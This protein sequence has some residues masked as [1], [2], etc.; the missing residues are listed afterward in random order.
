MLNAGQVQ[1]RR[2]LIVGRTIS[3]ASANSIGRGASSGLSS[4][5]SLPVLP[6]SG[7]RP[8]SVCWTAREVILSPQHTGT[9]VSSSSQLPAVV[10]VVG[11]VPPLALGTLSPPLGT[12]NGDTELGVSETTE[13]ELDGICLMPGTARSSDFT[14]DVSTADGVSVRPTCCQ[15]RG[16]DTG[17]GVVEWLFRD[18]MTDLVEESCEDSADVSSAGSARLDSK[19]HQAKKVEAEATVPDEMHQTPRTDAMDTHPSREPSCWSWAGEKCCCSYCKRADL[20]VGEDIVKDGQL[21]MAVSS[22]LSPDFASAGPSGPET[23]SPGRPE[24]PYG[25]TPS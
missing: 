9:T 1:Q 10:T 13:S 22:G 14:S 23:G 17:A 11:K 15:V 8:A 18:C 25:L 12:S 3:L 21:E 5:P 2:E 24:P 19:K 6:S 4:S 7:L 16:V 20:S